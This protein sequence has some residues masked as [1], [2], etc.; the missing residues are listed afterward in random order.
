MIE[1]RDLGGAQGA[2]GIGFE[3]TEEATVVFEAF[4]GRYTTPVFKNRLTRELASIE[5][6]WTYPGYVQNEK[7]EWTEVIMWCRRY[8]DESTD[9]LW[10]DVYTPSGQEPSWDMVAPLRETEHNFG[11]VPVE[12]VQNLTVSDEIDGDPDCHGA[13]DM[14][15]EADKLNSQA[16]RGVVNN[17][18]PTL[19]L[20]TDDESLTSIEK[21]SEKFIRLNKGETAEYLEMNGMGS[22]TAGERADA[23]ESKVLRFCQCVLDRTTDVQK[24]A[25]ETEYDYSSFHEKCD[26]L[27]EQYGERGVK[28]LLAKLVKAVKQVGDE[29]V[30]VP[31]REETQP[32]G[33]KKLVQRKLGP[34]DGVIALQWPD[35]KT[36]TPTDTQTKV[37]SAANAVSSS[38]VD[39]QH[40]AQYVAP[41]FQVEDVVAMLASIAQQKAA[42]DAAYQQATV[43]EATAPV[44]DATDI[45]S[46][47]FTQGELDA[48]LVT[49]NEWRASKGLGPLAVDGDLNIPQFKAKYQQTFAQ[50]T[51]ATSPQTA[52]ELVGMPEPGGA[53]SQSNSF[54]GA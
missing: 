53:P 9:T 28:R 51:V 1:V 6:K 7:G 37:Q 20:V 22:K 5:Q 44:D 29:S 19:V 42:D 16:N 39:L 54:G 21:G 4:D 17:C 45:T 13:F 49:M 50:A 3:F 43:G 41:D 23:L 10:Q 52:A 18:D 24:T 30:V 32:D 26:V 35:Y 27:R 38:L 48:G 33:T 15:E 31:P 36:A 12:W 46:M 34:G 47:K 14:I 25:T 8:I 11:F 40:A 2:V